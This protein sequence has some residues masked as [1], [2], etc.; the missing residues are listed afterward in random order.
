MKEV[1]VVYDVAVREFAGE[2]C[3]KLRARSLGELALICDEPH[4][5]LNE[6]E[7]ICRAL[8]NAGADKNC[9]LIAIGGG[10]CSDVCGLAASLYKRGIDF[11][12]VPTTLLAMADASVGGKNGVNLDGVKNMI[13]TF[14]LPR[15]IH[16]RKEVLRTLPR[17]EVLSGSA[18]ILKT[19]L[20][21]DE[22]LY[23]KAV[24]VFSELAKMDST[25]GNGQDGQAEQEEML[26]EAAELAEKAAKYKRK[27]VKRDLFDRGRRHILN[28]GHTFA[29]AIEWRSHEGVSHG[30]AVSMG[31]IKSLRM[32]E[33]EGWSEKGLADRVRDDFKRCNLPVELPYSDEELQEALKNDKK[34]EEGAVDFVFLQRIGKPFRKKIRL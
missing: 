10:V 11:E 20:L 26:G 31:I 5:T 16:I 32:S 12:I 24:G 14:K 34:A 19:F 13:G 30:E 6:V 1:F 21:F 15:K 7:H 27:V 22:K 18:E 8:M 17:K 4:K 3:N 28:F 29:H 23:N 9:T 2:F 33:K 25:G